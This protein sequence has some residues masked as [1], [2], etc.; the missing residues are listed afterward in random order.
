ARSSQK[1]GAALHNFEYLDGDPATAGPAGFGAIDSFWN[2]RRQFCGTY[3]EAW[4]QQRH[5]LLPLDWDPRCLLCAPQDQQPRQPLRGGEQVELLNLTPQGVL[6]FELPKVYL[7]FTTHIDNRREE[8]RSQLSTVLI[9][10]D[11]RRL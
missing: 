5:P 9:E 8:H 7:T 2:P 10:P 4:Q 11:Q 3:D 6:R 1:E